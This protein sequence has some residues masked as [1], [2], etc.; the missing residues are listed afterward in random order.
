M[1]QNDFNDLSVL[2]IGYRRATNIEKILEICAVSSITSIYISIDGPKSGNNEG[3]A[4]YIKIK[5]C[6]D[7]FRNSFNGKIQVY[8]RDTNVGCAASVMSSCDWFFSQI[9]YGII[10]EDDCIPSIDFFKF[11][12]DMRGYIDSKPNIW[13]ACGSQFIPKQLL[14]DSPFVS[15]YALTW[16]W[17]TSSTKWA[18]I[19]KSVFSRKK[20]ANKI[21]TLNIIDRVYWNAG[22]RRAYQGFTDVWDTILVQQMLEEKK[23]ALLPPE[24]LVTNIG[25]DFAA[26]HTK[27]ASVLLNN[28][29]GRYCVKEPKLETNQVLDAWI[30]NNV[31]KIS[32][33]HLITT[34]L[35]WLLDCFFRSRN[36][37]PLLGRWQSAN[38]KPIR[39]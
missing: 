17:A 32:F 8:I 7:G 19:K 29:L 10:L 30:R 28:E 6:I 24:N 13:L 31:Y 3:F 5:N 26:T 27:D 1:I 21:R 4:D 16:G 9:E 34:K 18:E 38:I 2:I 36:F 37:E 20:F 25:N 11:A 33:K 22:A 35:T 39:N 12:L 14:T 15:K 23:F